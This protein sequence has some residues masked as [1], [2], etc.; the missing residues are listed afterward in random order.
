M[1]QRP[2]I[3]V[4]EAILKAA[5]EEFA[6]AGFEGA[7]LSDVVERAGTSIGNLYKYFGNK[8]ALFAEF[9][10][11]GFTAELTNRVRVQV[12]A[13]RGERD[14]FLLEPDHPYRRASESLLAFTLAHRER[15][16]FLLLRAQG[17][18]H[19][20]FVSEVVRS[21]VELALEHARST[22]PSFAT[23]PANKRALTRIYRGFVANL[24]RILVEERGERAVREAVATQTAY[25][26]CGLKALFEGLPRPGK[27]A[28]GYAR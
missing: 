21:L 18:K 26:L 1:P 15:V 19:E 25:H 24:G 16:V 17:T 9:I 14:V 27:S 20:R 5:A 10:P 28:G 6:D 8:E 11:S 22:Y 12:Q 4:R 23:T 7:A 3:E 13:L 2:K